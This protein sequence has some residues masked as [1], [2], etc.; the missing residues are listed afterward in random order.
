MGS[1]SIEA[2]F[3]DVPVLMKAMSPMRIVGAR[4]GV[5]AVAPLLVAAFLTTACVGVPAA[6]VADEES[7]RLLSGELAF[8]EAVSAREIPDVDLLTPSA[9]MQRF[10]ESEVGSAGAPLV[11]F[12]RMFRGLTKEGYFNTSYIADS[13]RTAAETFQHKSGNCLSYTSM[14]ISLARESGMNAGFQVVSVPPSWDADSGYL[15]RY[16]HVNVILKGFAYG[17]NRGT[18][19]SVDRGSEFS[20]DFNDVLPD[21]EYSRREI[22][23]VDATSL[24]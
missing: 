9:E 2:G 24:Y 23:D 6:P 7:A 8:G 12:R 3:E 11:K 1:A 10:I 20:V 17:N 21:P 13:T 5:M 15:I 16:T 19:F 22:S 14:F 18:D 4:K